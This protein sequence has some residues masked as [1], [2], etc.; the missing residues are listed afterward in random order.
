MDHPRKV[1]LVENDAFTRY[2]MKEIIEALGVAVDI[3]TDGGNGVER[4]TAQPGEYGLVLMDLHMPVLT[5]I[6]A[7]RQIRD[8]DSVV[9]RHVPI[10]AVTADAEYH[11]DM[12]VRNLGMNGFV[13]K[14]VTPGQLLSLIDRFC[15][16]A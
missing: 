9:A 5:G 16:T 10:I 8:A 1:L 4:V 2:M 11:D 13:S 6:E 14:P 15:P 12:V 7:T 3:A